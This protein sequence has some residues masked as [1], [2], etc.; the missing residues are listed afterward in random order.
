MALF[1]VGWGANH[2]VTLMPVYREQDHLSQT[3]VTSMFAA[4]VLGLIPA[5][6]IAARVGERVG[7]R[8]VIRAVLV[9]SVL[10]STLLALAGDHV[11]LL[12]AGRILYGACMGAAMA[13]GTTWV[14]ELSAGAPTGTGARRAA[15]ALSSGFGGGP[16]I[17]GV[18]AQWMPAP[19][20]LPYVVHVALTTVVMTIAWGTPQPE[21]VTTPAGGATPAGRHA[22]RTR[23]FWTQIAPVAPWVFTC[24]AVGFVILPSLVQAE[25]DGV[26]IAFTGLMAGITL[27]TGVLVQPTARRIEARHPGLVSLLGGGAA[28]LGVLFAVIITS[29]SSVALVLLAGVLLGCG[30]GMSL[31]GGLTRVERLAA[32]RQLAMTNACFYSLTYLGFFVPTIVSALSG[33]W[34]VR[35]SLIGLAVL[36]AATTAV[37]T[38]SGRTSPRLAGATYDRPPADSRI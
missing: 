1:V 34:S 25:I 35:W 16:L 30:Y 6:L 2:F 5:L 17:S 14:K 36:I 13:P 37:A 38:L 10:G 22:V 12:F 9:G 18:L 32:P 26:A 19:R 3:L 8:S 29:V 31:V 4:Y 27:G 28:L 24:A 23:T 20:V 11:V 21:H 15:V 7:H 33:L